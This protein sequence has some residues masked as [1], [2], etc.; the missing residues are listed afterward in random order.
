MTDKIEFPGGWAK[1]RDPEDVTERAR[2]PLVLV[3]EGIVASDVGQI[4][5]EKK[6]AG[7]EISD[8]EMG[9][10]MAPLI[11][12]STWEDF[13]RRQYDLNICA[14][15]EEWSFEAPVSVEALL[16]I[17][18]RAYKALRAECD[19][20]LPKVLGNEDEDEV[21]DPNSNFTDDSA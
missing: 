8:E 2:R 20:L 9:R 16:D 15:I 7:E 17:P 19:P 4:V 3:Q 14:L 18:G 5:M 6:A 11:G 1:L 13:H 10:M 21:T 12:S